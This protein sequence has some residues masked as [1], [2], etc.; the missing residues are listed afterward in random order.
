M[1]ARRVG[2]IPPAP[3][4]NPRRSATPNNIHNNN[5][6]NNNPAYNNNVL[7]QQQ[8][9]QHPGHAMAIP[10]AVDNNSAEYLTQLLKDKKQISAFPNVFLHLERLLDNEISR[11]RSQMFYTDSAKSP[12]ELPECSAND[13][14]QTLTEKVF[15]P[16]QEHPDFNFVGR[17]LGKV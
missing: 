8:Q 5:N 15:V 6:N 4:I 13:Q 11:V 9:Q 14:K 3:V 12:M 2:G 16:V 7:Q 17:I 10:P 1:D